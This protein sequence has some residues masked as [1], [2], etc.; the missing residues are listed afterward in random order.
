MNLFGRL[1]MAKNN[2]WKCT[3]PG[4]RGG[5]QLEDECLK[6]Y[7]TIK[8][9][10]N[11]WCSQCIWSPLLKRFTDTMIK[12]QIESN[13]KNFKMCFSLLLAFLLA[14]IF[15]RMPSLDLSLGSVVS[16]KH[17][18]RTPQTQGQLQLHWGCKFEMHD[19]THDGPGQSQT[20]LG[21][22]VTVM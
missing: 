22:T 20:C 6:G 7:G 14:S 12:P 16:Q 17:W 13:V 5:T 4:A 9:Y 21:G 11:H 19:R 2:I 3:D 1:K 10:G 8:S 15:Q 18:Q